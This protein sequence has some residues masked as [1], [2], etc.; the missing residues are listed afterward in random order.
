MLRK[1]KGQNPKVNIPDIFYDVVRWGTPKKIVRRVL[2]GIAV[3]AFLFV[4]GFVH[5][6]WF[7]QPRVGAP[8]EIVIEEGMT[9][10]DVRDL[11]ASRGLVSRA[12]YRLYG[13]LDRATDR[14]IAARYEFRKGTSYRAI[15]RTLAAGPVRKELTIRLV[16]GKTLDDEVNILEGLGVPVVSSTALVGES[17]NDLPFDRTLVATYPFLADIPEGMSLEGY[18]FP[19]TYRVWEDDVFDT[20]IHKQLDAFESNVIEP[21]ADEQRASGLTW[22]EIIT[23]ASIVEGETYKGDDR[24][25]VA[26]IF[27][28]R[29]KIGMALQSDAT[30]N[31]VTKAAR[32]RPTFADLATSSAYNTYQ[33]PGLP[34]GPIN[35][36]SLSAIKAVLEP[37]ETNYYFFLSDTQGRMYYGRTG[38]EHQR[39]RANVFGE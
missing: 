7:S 29:L 11:L 31:Y 20:I 19:D 23:L 39:N 10:Q 22:H 17:A 18:L 26:G 3:I 6:A 5:A 16:E 21:L 1:V 4:A 36:P 15:A 24:K 9:G 32:A 25:I 37:T 2:V 33:H 34:P 38:A 30:V 12:G 8:V 28:N 27:L 14:F 13:T 35:N